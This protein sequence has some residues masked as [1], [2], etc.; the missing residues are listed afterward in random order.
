[1]KYSIIIPY[2]S[3]RSL[4]HTCMD[5]LLKTTPDDIEI[6]VVA[7]NSD[8]HELEITMPPHCKLLKYSKS[9]YYPRA[10]NIGVQAAQG[11]Y[12]ILMDADICVRNGWFEALTACFN[13]H[14]DVGGCSAKMLDPFDGCLKEFGIAFTG[15]NFPHPFAGSPEGYPL[16]SHDRDVQAFCSATSMYRRDIY[17]DMGGMDEYLVDGYSDIDF[18]LRLHERGLHTYVA[19]NAVVYHHGSS[20]KRSGMS[21]HLRVDTKGIFMARN[22]HRCTVDM[23]SY[24]HLAFQMYQVPLQESYYLVDFT[25]IADKQWHYDLFSQIAGLNWSDTYNLPAGQR[26]ASHIPLYTSL[27][28]NIRRKCQPICYFVDDFRSLRNNR[29]WSELRNCGEDIIIDRNAN[30][31]SFCD[32]E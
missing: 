28:D 23:D 2:H 18:C 11:E 8:S 4:L 30:V 6:V 32:V 5:A 1:M 27:D 29:I 21:S 17:L 19:A 9:I 10:V 15:Y 22:G 7:N 26:N 13:T 24:Y 20:T 3:N 31:L 14:S 12:V 16:V 25:T